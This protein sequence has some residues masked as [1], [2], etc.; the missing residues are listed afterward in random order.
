MN[1]KFKK[2][3]LLAVVSLIIASCSL[4]RNQ[5]KGKVVPGDFDLITDFVTLKTVMIL[6]F[7]VNGISKNF[8]FDTGADYSLLQQD[9][10]SGKRGQVDGASKRTIEVGSEIISSMKIGNIDFRNTVALNAD[11][12]GLKSQVPNFGGLIGQTII[13]KANWLIDY[14]KKKVRISNKNLAT[15]S[16]ESIKLKVKE[17][18]PYTFIIIDGV[19][20]KVIIDF[21]SSSA[22]NLPEDSDLAHK[23][24]AKYKFVE[25][26]RERYTLGGV[27]K[28]KEK[29]G[30]IP[31]IKLGTMTF[32]DVPTTINISSQ[33]R[34]GIGFFKDCEIYIDNSNNSYK[35]KMQR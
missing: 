8:I 18:A 7:E 33:P 17:G 24:L 28:T 1:I 5:N 15:F 10:I 35:I 9:S 20:Y 21:G 23:L 25:S 34:I 2:N 30:V 29:I 31:I 4:Q 11:M 26:E 32:E 12:K 14:P 27:Q 13:K 3:L 22:F 16:F 6:P 19:E